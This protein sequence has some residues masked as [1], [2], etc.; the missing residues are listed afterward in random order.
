M[1]PVMEV[2]SSIQG[3]GSSV[4]RISIFIRLG[5]CN[6]SCK[7]FNVKYKDP[8]TGEEKIGCDSFY[9]VDPAFK[10]EWIK[11]N[12]FDEIVDMVDKIMP[13]YPK[14]VLTKPDIVITGGEPT[15]YWDNPEFQKL[16][17]YY[18]SRNHCVTIETNASLDIDFKREYQR[19]IKFSMSTK[20]SNSG[21]PENKRININNIT[22]IVENSPNSYLKFVVG[23]D[24]ISDIETEIDSILKEIPIYTIVF[25]MPLGDNRET[26]VYNAEA[27][28]DMC[29]RK[30]FQY[31]DRTHIRI[32]GVKRGV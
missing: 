2:F 3:E 17:A 25:L 27:V 7:G 23:K 13:I 14:A 5:G 18:V 28:I 15:L 4:G 31:S 19:K 21:E 22:N 30:G 8:K 6:F 9:S 20:L 24:Y 1:I 11:T 10:N 26:L 29:I 32:W 12:S 16:L